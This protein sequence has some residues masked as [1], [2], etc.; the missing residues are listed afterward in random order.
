MITA[1]LLTMDRPFPEPLFI[2]ASGVK[3]AIY[4]A[5]GDPDRKRRP[6]ILVHG[7]PEIAYSWRNQLHVLAAAGYRTIA[8]DLKGFGRSDTPKDVR[9]YDIEHVT[10]DLCTI[11]DALDI[12]QAV[13]CGHDWGGAIVW[14]MGQWRA[15]RVAAIISICTPLKPRPPVSPIS[16][17]KKR[18]GEA[19]YFVQF[20]EPDTP[21]TLFDADIERFVKMMF[22]TPPPRE[23]WAALIP[24]IYDLPGRFKQAKAPNPDKLIVSDATIQV[25]VDA[26]KRS[27]FHGGINLYRN[28]D[29]N[30]ELMAGRNET[31]RAPSLWI[32]AELDIFLPPESADGMEDIVPDLEKHVI[33]DCGHWVMWEKPAELNALLINWLDRKISI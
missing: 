22:Q 16:I 11:L 4:E 33:G 28:I 9:A 7:W 12:E 25:Y 14:S 27:G 17:F 2:D 8:I 1:T 18:F 19:H 3:I 23:R 15:D 13:F 10:N 30:W 24:R 31:I 20:Q 6:I 32:G 26:Y 29:R 21:E 5:D